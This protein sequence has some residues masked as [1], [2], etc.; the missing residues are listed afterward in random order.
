MKLL[1]LWIALFALTS[2]KLIIFRK[3]L[4]ILR[5]EIDDTTFQKNL[6][7]NRNIKELERLYNAKQIEFLPT[8]NEKK[9]ISQIEEFWTKKENEKHM[10][11]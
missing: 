3:E 1:F 4:E 11:P 5:K 6:D 9:R 7:R 2:S 8:T 10:A